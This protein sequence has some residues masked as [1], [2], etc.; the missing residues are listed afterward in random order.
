MKPDP[1]LLQDFERNRKSSIRL[2]EVLSYLRQDHYMSKKTA[3]E[4]SGLSCR[5]L[6]KRRDIPRYQLAGKTLFRRSELDSWLRQFR[7]C[8]EGKERLNLDALADELKG[9]K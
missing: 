9:K 6:E 3:A 4:Y 1:Q 5:T 2:D 8:G 7:V